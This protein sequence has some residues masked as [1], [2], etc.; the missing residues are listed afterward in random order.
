M[1]IFSA[2]FKSGNYVRNSRMDI[3]RAEIET[4]QIADDALLIKLLPST[5][6]FP[7]N[8]IHQTGRKAQAW[9]SKLCKKSSILIKDEHIQ[10]HLSADSDNSITLSALVFDI[11]LEF[12]DAG[13]LTNTIVS[14][15]N[16]SWNDD[17]IDLLTANLNTAIHGAQFE[18]NSEAW[19]RA[20]VR[21][22]NLNPKTRHLGGGAYFSY[23][24]EFV[25]TMIQW[26]D[27]ARICDQKMVNYID[28]TGTNGT[29]GDC[30]ADGFLEEFNEMIED[31]STKFDKQIRNSSI[32]AKL[33]LLNSHWDF[34]QNNLSHL[35][36]AT[37]K[38]E[39]QKKSLISMLE[40]AKAENTRE[41]HYYITPTGQELLRALNDEIMSN[42]S[43]ADDAT[44]IILNGLDSEKMSYN[45]KEEMDDIIL[46]LLQ[47]GCIEIA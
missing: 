41:M 17:N 36:A 34:I 30:L 14:A 26:C 38:L 4:R 11:T 23:D 16:R 19:Q 39:Q 25:Q 22:M 9:A 3:V 40:S 43:V 13:V 46:E 15:Q 33:D 28:S 27:I 31:L 5:Q 21:A 18:Y 24:A 47:E 20:Y 44:Y 2:A 7:E 12:D 45:P 42:P 35:S 10:L 29:I 6:E 1:K 32:E 8:T 37:Q